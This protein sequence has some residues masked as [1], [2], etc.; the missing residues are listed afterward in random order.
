MKEFDDWN[1]LK[2][3]ISSTS[4]VFNVKEREIY[5]LNIDKNIGNEQNGKGEYFLRPVIVL[6]KLN[7]DIFMGIPTSSK[8][9]QGNFFFY[10]E[11]ME[12]NSRWTQTGKRCCYIGTNKNI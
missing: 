11:F 10:F 5:Y 6:K 2:K 1:R 7:K 4:G 12:K 9:K 3:E 8:I